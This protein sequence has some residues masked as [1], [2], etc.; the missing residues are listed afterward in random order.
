MSLDI[1]LLARTY[2][3][4]FQCNITHNLTEMA[5]KAG[6]YVVLWRPEEEEVTKAYKAIPLLE[7]GIRYMKAN[8]AKLLKYNPANGWGCYDNLLKAAEDYL[9]A[10]REF[11]NAKIL[12][13][14]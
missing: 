3:N 4:V 6:L 7:E 9:V 8:K 1:C 12:V 5:A 13:D 2:N 14:R 11:P 10:C